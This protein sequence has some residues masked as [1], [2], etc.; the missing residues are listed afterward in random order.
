MLGA[1]IADRLALLLQFVT[2]LALV[3]IFFY[4]P[5]VLPMLVRRTVAVDPSWTDVPAVWFAAQYTAMVGFA[6]AAVSAH[7]FVAI[8]ALG[9]ALAIVVPVYLLPAPLMARRALESQSRVRAGAFAR[10]TRTTSRMLGL[11]PVVGSLFEFTVAS[12]TRSHRHLLVVATYLGVAIAA[13]SIA[14]IAARLDA[15]MVAPT[16]QRAFLSLPL[17]LMFFGSIGL[18]AAFNIPTELA[19]NWPFRLITPTAADA[20]AAARVAIAVLVVV[21]VTLVAAAVTAAAGWDLR[22]VLTLAICE[23][24]AGLALTEAVLFAW[25]KVPFTC[26][27][28]PATSTIRSRWL[29]AVV[30]VNLY[31]FR[32]ADLQRLALASVGSSVVYVTAMAALVLGLRA[33]GSR[34][35]SRRTID[36]DGPGEDGSVTLNL[37][38]AL[39]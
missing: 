2:V 38:E 36:F 28:A 5:L 27:H 19:A 10:A 12:L 11:K 15:G 9:L 29:L 8:Q 32:G 1:A 14:L 6:P 24:L 25:S 4:L 17:V 16:P 35:A 23:L 3:E 30:A 22:L 37:S 39:Q 18:R 21:P 31:A 7:A 34:D 33:I 20:S 26:A 13:G